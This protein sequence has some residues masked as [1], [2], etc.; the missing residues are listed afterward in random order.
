MLK[1]L[2]PAVK[3]K[4]LEV[5]NT[6]LQT[7]SYPHT[8]KSATVIPIPKPNKTNPEINSFRPISL[9]PC[10]GK[11]VEKMIARRLMWFTTQKT[12]SL[13][14]RLHSKR[15]TALWMLC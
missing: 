1:N 13:I 3:D 5:F 9:L 7:G 10:L 2:P 15:V 12:V 6:M 11:T 4:L 8:W 14:T